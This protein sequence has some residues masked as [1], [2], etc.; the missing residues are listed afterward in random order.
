M[1]FADTFYKN[2]ET[3]DVNG[4]V[5]KTRADLGSNS[6]RHRPGKDGLYN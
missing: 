6:A 2:K 4:I 1:D 3:I 5:K